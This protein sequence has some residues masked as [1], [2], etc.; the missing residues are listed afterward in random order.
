ML[1]LVQTPEPALGEY[2]VCRSA[3]IVRYSARIVRYSA[4]IVRYSARIVRYSARIVRYICT[5]F[6]GNIKNELGS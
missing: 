1:S 3:R 6:S 2:L 5:C 4:R